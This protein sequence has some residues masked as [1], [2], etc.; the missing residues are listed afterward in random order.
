MAVLDG[1]TVAKTT[2]SGDAMSHETSL[3][4]LV[5]V[6]ADSLWGCSEQASRLG[7]ELELELEPEPGLGPEL[8][9]Q[10][11]LQW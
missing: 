2:G 8:Q 6:S 7:L 3:Q 11:R 4:N 1:P 10:L 5:F 9:M